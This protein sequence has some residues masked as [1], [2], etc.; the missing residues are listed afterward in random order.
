MYTLVA[1]GRLPFRIPGVLAAVAAGTVLYYILGPAGWAGGTFAAPSA[2]LHFGIP[3]PTLDFVYGLKESLRYLP[4]ALPFAIVPVVGGINV[5]ESARVA[6]DDYNT[7]HVLLTEA[8]ATLIAG[9]CGGVAQTTP[10]IGHP[11]Y[12]KMGS[13]AGS[14]SCQS[15]RRMQNQ[16]VR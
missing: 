12:K 15:R 10:Y 4:I 9:L 16:S 13:R 7:R 8:V 1:G 14:S 2:N 3:V 6:G 5:T 11:A